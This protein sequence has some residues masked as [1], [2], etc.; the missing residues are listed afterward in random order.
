MTRAVLSPGWDYKKRCPRFG[1]VV[2]VENYGNIRCGEI[3]EEG[4]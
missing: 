1:V 4:E 3:A 2:N